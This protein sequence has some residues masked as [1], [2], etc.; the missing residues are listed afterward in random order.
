MG[1]KPTSEFIEALLE[2]RSTGI[3][4]DLKLN[5]RRLIEESSLS[6]EEAILVLL[7]TATAVDH[8]SL[9]SHSREKLVA[10]GFSSEQI[11]EA[12]ESAAMMGMLNLYY[13][14]R[15]MVGNEEDYKTANLR[16]TSLARP[17]LGKEKYE[18][19][20]F[21]VS[22]INGCSSCIQAHEKV[23]R[24]SGLSADKVHDLA[25][26]ASVVNGLKVLERSE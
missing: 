26:M 19:L 9:I 6:Q 20:A 16:M 17:V 25:R 5:L 7:A 18:M 10:L 11:Q 15:H 14:F 12:A 24:G 8:R 3:A 2:T 4:R 13:R 23:L 21:A 1:D 22:V